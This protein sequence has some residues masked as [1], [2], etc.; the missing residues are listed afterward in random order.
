MTQL[1]HPSIV[2]TPAALRCENGQVAAPLSEL[3][4]ADAAAWRAWL[5][6]PR[7][8]GWGRA[9]PR[10]KGMTRADKPTYDKEPGGRRSAMRWIDGEARRRDERTYRQRFTPDG[11]RSQMVGAQRRQR[12]ATGA[13]KERIARGAG[14]RWS[15]PR[16]TAAGRAAPPGRAR[17]RCLRPRHGAGRR[18]QGE[19]Q[20]RDAL[21]QNATRCAYG[22]TARSEARPGRRIEDFVAMLARRETLHPRK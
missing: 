10:E 20:V 4:V 3:L 16:R 15:G 22:S 6:A 7:R 9:R 13:P 2:D 8:R 18:A 21:G 19:G 14:A 5:G 12:R 1:R 11:A 17:P